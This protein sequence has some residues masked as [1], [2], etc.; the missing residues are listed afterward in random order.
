MFTLDIAQNHVVTPVEQ[1]FL[2][3][4]R[5]TVLKVEKANNT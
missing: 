1:W 2:K 3:R 4:I 5:P